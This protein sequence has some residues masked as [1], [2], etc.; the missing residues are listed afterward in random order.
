MT[1]PDDLR[2]KLLARRRAEGLGDDAGFTYRRVLKSERVPGTKT[3]YTCWWEWKEFER[4][5][6]ELLKARGHEAA[7]ATAMVRGLREGDWPFA[8]TDTMQAALDSVDT[9]IEKFDE[10]LKKV[11]AELGELGAKEDV[12]P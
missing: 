3:L 8:I 7:E 4:S 6:V 1:D 11:D 12:K 5:V 9:N 10:V 2:A